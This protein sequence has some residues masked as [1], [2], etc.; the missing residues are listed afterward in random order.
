MR[1]PQHAN[2]IYKHAQYD[3]TDWKV[4]E[5]FPEP[6]RQKCDNN[7]HEVQAEAITELYCAAVVI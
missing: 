7:G 5:F 3:Q 2:I 1:H 4:W 6:K